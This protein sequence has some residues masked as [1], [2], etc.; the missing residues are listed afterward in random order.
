MHR[1]QADSAIYA[2]VDYMGISEAPG[3]STALPSLPLEKLADQVTQ[4]VVEGLMAGIPA[5]QLASFIDQRFPELSSTQVSRLL[6]QSS[7]MIQQVEQ[8]IRKPGLDSSAE[9]SL[10]VSGSREL[11]LMSMSDGDMFLWDHDGTDTAVEDSCEVL[12]AQR[13]TVVEG[14]TVKGKP[15]QGTSE[16]LRLGVRV[17]ARLTVLAAFAGYLGARALWR[18]AVALYRNWANVDEAVSVPKKKVVRRRKKRAPRKEKFATSAGPTFEPPLEEW[19]D[20]T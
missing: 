2:G 20:E 18:R 15:R 7:H 12:L 3:A 13:P 8:S 14:A 9:A 19:F 5:N 16:R 4:V 11:A 1:T 6:D 10:D 17:L